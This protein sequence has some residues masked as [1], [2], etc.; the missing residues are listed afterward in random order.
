MPL[1]NF[2][3]IGAVVFT[4][5]VFGVLTRRNLLFIFMSLEIM[6]A[7]VALT[8]LAFARYGNPA[9]PVGQVFIIFIL[10]I[11]AAETALGIGIFLAAQRSY[12]TIAAD[13]IR[14]LKG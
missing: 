6:F 14:E 10:A 13:E 7:G 8:I 4:L 1:S 12:Q 3:V 5:G 2:L 11:A 9:S